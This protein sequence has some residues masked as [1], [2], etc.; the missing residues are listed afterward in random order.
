MLQQ[1]GVT[2][3]DLRAIEC[4]SRRERP[5]A[6]W[7]RS[8]EGT[9]YA[10][11]EYLG[12]IVDFLPTLKGRR[13]PT[14]SAN[15]PSPRWRCTRSAPRF[16]AVACCK[17]RARVAIRL[18]NRPGGRNNPPKSARQQ[19]D[20]GR[21]DCREQNRALNYP[22]KLDAHSGGLSPICVAFG[23]NHTNYPVDVHMSF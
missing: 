12:T 8:F 22:W 5:R 23:P 20:A 13:D 10:H 9:I 3:Q 11:I 1:S 16:K 19:I 17:E 6:A 4:I 18:Q 14:S 15:H 7:K 21:F 2:S